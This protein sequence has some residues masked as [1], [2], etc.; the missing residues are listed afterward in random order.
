MQIK[1]STREALF[2]ALKEGKATQIM[3]PPGNYGALNLTDFKPAAPV[4]IESEDPLRPAEFDP[5]T[6]RRVT[7]IS[8]KGGAF[9]R[10]RKPDEPGWVTNFTI[11]ASTDFGVLDCLV[12]GTLDGD[13][14]NDC[15]GF[16]LD[17]C[18]RAMLH[19]NKVREAI[20]AFALTRCTDMTV[21]GQHIREV[22]SDGMVIAAC[23]RM[24]I[25]ENDIAEVFPNAADHP[26]GIQLFNQETKG[27]D[28]QVNG[29]IVCEDID[30]VGNIIRQDKGTGNQGIFARTTAGKADVPGYGFR[31]FRVHNNLIY[32]RDYYHGINITDV[33]DGVEITSNTVISPS[34][35]AKIAWIKLGKATG[36]VLIADN[37]AD[38][39]IFDKPPPSDAVLRNNIELQKNPAAR[40]KLADIDKR[41]DARIAGLIMDGVGYQPPKVITLPPVDP[42]DAEIA[43]LQAELAKTEALLKET[44]G[45]NK[46]L[47]DELALSSEALNRLNEAVTKLNSELA[48]LRIDLERTEGMRKSAT[49]KLSSISAIIAES[50]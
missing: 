42:R 21:F 6:W 1:A 46:S 39:L 8:L 47:I 50:A 45:T 35:D 30:I 34:D 11:Y 26:D 5:T 48:A 10:V 24:R 7:G 14:S 31:N 36:K 29:V 49:A 16:R 28:G 38:Q 18:A 15:Q 25:V 22:R 43:R 4:V 19:G 37:V 9:R 23:K 27:A 17:D 33:I 44:Q 41:A 32:I 2:D 3:L 12:E 20:V 13:P 40:A